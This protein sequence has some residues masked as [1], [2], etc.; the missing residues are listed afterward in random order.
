MRIPF[1]LLALSLCACQRPS[2]PPD[3]TA[4][5]D[6]F[7]GTGGHGHTY[8][9]ATLPFGMVQLSPDNGWGGWDWS[10]GYHYDKMQI[11]GFSHTHVSG[12]GVGDMLDV[13]VQPTTLPLREQTE[14]GGKIWANEY[15]SA[16][17]HEEETAEPGYYAVRL[18]DT[19]IRAELT[20]TLRTG[21]HRYA[22]PA[23]DSA[24]VLFDLA[25]SVNRD[26]PT[27]TRIEVL[28][29][30]RL[31]GYRYSTGWAQDQRVYFYAEFSRPFFHH[32]L[33]A[34]GKFSPEKAAVSGPYTDAAF[35]FDTREDSLVL[36][37]VG[38]SS[39]SMAGA[40]ANLK[41]ENP[42]W[43]F[44]AIRAQARGAWQQ[45]LQV[46]QVEM[47]HDSLE[48]IFYTALYHAQL[49]P[50]LYSDVDGHYTA[51]DGSVQRAEGFDHYHTYSLWDTYRA[52]NPLYTLIAPQRVQ[53]FA[54]SMLRIYEESGLLP[55]WWLWGNETNTM[56]GYHAVPVLVDAYR[57]G[58]LPEVDAE[59]LYAALLASGEQEI[60]HSPLYRQYGY[61]PADSL[62]NTVSTTLEYAYDDWCIAQMAQALG[63]QADYERYQARS[64]YFRNLF[65]PETKLMRAKYANGDWKTPF[66]P[67]LTAYRNDY[68]EGNAWQFVWYVP[69]DV[70][71][72]VE[73]MGGNAPFVEL[74][75]S[76]FSMTSDIGEDA[77]SDVTGLIGQYVHGNEPS[78][79]IAYLYNY[80]GA[81]HKTQEKVRQILLEMYGAHPAGL[82]GNE[83][84]G[85]MSAWYIFSALG[86]Y[87]VNP[88]SGYYDLGSPLVERA[89]IALPGG[90]T[91]RVVAE[92]QSLA[93]LYVQ[94]V[95]WNGEPITDWRIAHA[96]LMLGGE[97][98]FVMGPA[99][100]L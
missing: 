21:M 69:Q 74:L 30:R 93:N 89:E 7:I 53:D 81:P 4:K 3:L 75:D 79:H 96:D 76:V 92:N 54:Q 60:R 78:H 14:R 59:Q 98:Q 87:P 34:E 48:T 55:V 67:F 13:L 40:E 35:Y 80:A 82:S 36:L 70:P 11:I 52:A 50:N 66:D 2:P 91:L 19:D 15:V 62:N 32:Q 9:G 46:I 57:K 27:D 42:G 90:K 6:P 28:D 63:K 43:D 58:L 5:V 25:W 99:P 72:L 20:A 18:A 61:I 12:T 22:F 29:D 38:I 8:P 97:L 41:A 83:D 17:S 51:T 45:A 65:D 37:K 64:Q 68:T 85:Q 95:T 31:Q 56:I 71:A 77:A 10:G 47:P 100:K 84:C 1:L 49:A 88:A 73:L 33:I 39:A 44:D 24:L 26:E 23:R 16:Y 86:F 94:S